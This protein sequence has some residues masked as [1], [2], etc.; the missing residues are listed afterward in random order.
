MKS[1]AL[2][3]PRAFPFIEPPSAASLETAVGY[4]KQQGALDW[5]ENLTPIG[6]L[7]AELPV[8]VVVGE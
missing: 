1:M 7:L 5:Q 6:S 8:D 4:L 3:D 2:G